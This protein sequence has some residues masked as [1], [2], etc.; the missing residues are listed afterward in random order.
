MKNMK[1][2]NLRRQHG[3]FRGSLIILM[4]LSVASTALAV[5]KSDANGSKNKAYSYTGMNGQQHAIRAYFPANHNPSDK[6]PCFVFFHGGAWTGGHLNQG[7]L[8][9]EYLSSRGMV[10]IT[11]NY[12]MHPKE[13]QKQLPEGE[14]RKRI[15]VMD[16]K[17]VIRWVKEHADELGINPERMVVS[18]ASAGGHIGVLSMMDRDFSNPE[19]PKEINTE[20]QAFILLCP[21]FTVLAKDTSS[22]VNVFKHLDKQFPPTLF[23]VGETD[24]WK[25]ASDVLVE[26]LSAKN[27]EVDVWMGP[28]AGHMFFRTE[29]WRTPTLLRM[30]AFLTAKG[31]LEGSTTLESTPDDYQLE[32]IK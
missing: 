7:N 28:S 29:G 12:S 15:C 32:N 19:D 5:K 30:D 22:D 31:F 6:A 2:L 9:C 20:V 26:K 21:A 1:Q 3:L 14:S 8:F 11:E 23:I 13:A 4:L 18:G 10:A 24:N 27:E 16:G 25:N 17:T